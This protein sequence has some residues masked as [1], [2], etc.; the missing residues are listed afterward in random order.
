MVLTPSKSSKRTK[1]IEL[2]MGIRGRLLPSFQRW[3]LRSCVDTY[4]SSSHVMPAT[5][6]RISLALSYLTVVDC[7]V[8]HV[9]CTGVL[10]DTEA[11]TVRFVASLSI[12]ISA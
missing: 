3:W 5:A 2:K 8:D 9:A 7:Q 11:S 10:P 6:C 1:E 4:S 12:I